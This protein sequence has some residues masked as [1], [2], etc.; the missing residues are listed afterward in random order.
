MFSRSPNSHTR[1]FAKRI[2]G[3][4]LAAACFSLLIFFISGHIVGSLVIGGV[5]LLILLE[6]IYFDYFDT[7]REER[8]RSPKTQRDSRRSG[9]ESGDVVD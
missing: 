8:D 9:T 6:T 3:H 1:R 7:K 4:F 5:Y 2:A